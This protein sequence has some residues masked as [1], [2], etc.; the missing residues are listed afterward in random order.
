MAEDDVKRMKKL[1][2][3]GWRVRF[4][5]RRKH[6]SVRAWVKYLFSANVGKKSWGVE[7]R[8]CITPDVRISRVGP[9]FFDRL[10]TRPELARE[11]AQMRHAF[12]TLYRAY[13]RLLADQARQG[14][15]TP[16]KEPYLN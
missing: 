16:P 11:L 3:R 9:V 4:V 7:G 12:T 2:L 10:L 14:K 13:E 8:C 6:D 1:W 15:S 5:L